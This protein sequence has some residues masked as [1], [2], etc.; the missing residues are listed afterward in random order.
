MYSISHLCYLYLL[1][2]ASPLLLLL[3]LLSSAPPSL[4]YCRYTYY[5][6]RYC[7][8]SLARPLTSFNKGKLSSLLPS[9]LS[10]HIHYYHHRAQKRNS[11]ITRGPLSS[12]LF[13]IS[14][15]LAL[16]CR[17]S[18]RK[19]PVFHQPASIETRKRKK[20]THAITRSFPFDYTPTVQLKVGR[21][22]KKRH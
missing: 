1:N 13:A 17:A 15:R 11:F 9:L 8:R 4:P 21:K 7:S 16:L 19:M 18:S 10:P 12:P 6:D 5:Y 22:K 3:L 20:N 14:S 2:L